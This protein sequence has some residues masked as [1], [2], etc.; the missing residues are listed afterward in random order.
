MTQTI[1]ES[2]QLEGIMDTKSF[3]FINY[4]KRFYFDNDE[5]QNRF[6]ASFNNF[7][8]RNTRDVHQNYTHSFEIQGYE[9]HVAYTA[10]GDNSKSIIFFYVFVLL[11]LGLPYACIFER[12]VARY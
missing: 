8:A 6:I 10:M 3:I 2:G 5:S 7:V 11:G 9:E 4:I 1:D 12:G